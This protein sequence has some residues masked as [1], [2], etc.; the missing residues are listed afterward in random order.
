MAVVLDINFV[1]KSMIKEK[2][3]NELLKEYNAT[4]ST[5]SSIDNWMWENEQEVKYL[6]QVKSV[7]EKK[8]IVVI[9]LKTSSLKD[10][11]VYI[12]KFKNI[13]FYTLWINTESYPMLDCER[14]TLENEMYYE[15]IYQAIAKMDQNNKRTS[16]IFGI[17][18][19][20]DIY[21]SENMMNVIQNSRNMIVWVINSDIKVDSS[22][23]GYDKKT[24]KGLTIYEKKDICS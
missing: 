14:V 4:I 19:E 23:K 15:K 12:E 8:K 5:I 3:I 7:I 13:Y 1:S 17:G 10:L 18:L 20:T 6:N 11:G 24:V 9:Q 21:Y 16:G 22:I 2:K